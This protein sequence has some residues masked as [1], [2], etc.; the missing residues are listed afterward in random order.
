MNI[1][2][3]AFQLLSLELDNVLT[4]CYLQNIIVISG[5]PAGWTEWSAWS[6]C[7]L[8]CIGSD[9]TPGTH[10]RSR[11]CP[12]GECNGNEEEDGEC[13]LDMGLCDDGKGNIFN[14]LC[15]V[16]TGRIRIIADRIKALNLL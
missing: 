1:I 4:I 3:F 16:H 15:S 5:S 14:S 7:S 11:S 8:S 6:Q 10:S 9:G 2:D 12:D 13:G